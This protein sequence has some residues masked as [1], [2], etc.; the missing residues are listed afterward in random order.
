MTW[1]ADSRVVSLPRAVVEYEPISCYSAVA[2]AVRFAGLSRRGD[3][4]RQV[5]SILVVLAGLVEAYRLDFGLLFSSVR[6][7]SVVPDPEAD[8]RGAAIVDLDL[9]PYPALGDAIRHLEAIRGVAEAVVAVEEASSRGL[10]GAASDIVADLTTDLDRRVF[11]CL[12]D[13]NG[14]LGSPQDF[15][16]PSAIAGPLLC[17]DILDMVPKNG[18]PPVVPVSPRRDEYGGFPLRL[19]YDYENDCVGIRLRFSMRV[20][21][22]EESE[23]DFPPF[24]R[25]RLDRSCAGLPKIKTS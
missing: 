2:E 13:S 9:Q 7:M 21:M 23:L 4:P 11:A 12:W 22:V 18:E 3:L 8:L 6:R 1:S 24:D 5:R 17:R 10:R 15:W 14:L 25:C 16:E 20:A 19:R